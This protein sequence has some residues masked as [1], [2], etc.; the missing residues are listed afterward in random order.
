[1]EDKKHCYEGMFLL[2]A[3]KGTFEATVEPLQKILA[4]SE[5]EVVMMKPWDELKLAYEIKDRKRGLYVLTYF[6]VDPAKVVE[7]E[8]DCQISED[9]LRM[10]LIRR[11]SISDDELSAETPAELAQVQAAEAARAAEAA[12]AAAEET[13]AKEETTPADDEPQ[14]EVIEALEDAA[15]V[16]HEADMIED[17]VSAE[18]VV[19]VEE[20]EPETPE[21]PADE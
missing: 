20:D 18:Q 1:M 10:L 3:G 19:P 17:T 9:I 8:H 4:R 21:K 15:A 6:K 2:D 13:P 14:D 7:I 5:V 16:V 11:D 12:A